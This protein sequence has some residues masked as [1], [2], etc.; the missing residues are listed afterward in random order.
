MSLSIDFPP[1]LVDEIARRA[2]EIIQRDRVR[3][4]W[5]TTEECADYMRCDRKRVYDLVSQG[6]LPVHKDGTRSV[7]FIEEVDAYLFGSMA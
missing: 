7:F 4:P 3:S 1:E 2:A 5:M 6:R